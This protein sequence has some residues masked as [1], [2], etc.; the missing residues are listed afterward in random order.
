MSH[1][2]FAFLLVDKSRHLCQNIAPEKKNNKRLN[3]QTKE[4]RKHAILAHSGL[5]S[6]LYFYKREVYKILHNK[7]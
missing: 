2:Y 6:N 7:L 5:Q 1:L 3:L 4:N